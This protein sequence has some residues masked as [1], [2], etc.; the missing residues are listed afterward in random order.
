MVTNHLLCRIA[1]FV[2]LQNND[3]IWKKVGWFG[4]KLAELQLK[5]LVQSVLKII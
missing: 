2:A 4:D 1:I 5:G 3:V